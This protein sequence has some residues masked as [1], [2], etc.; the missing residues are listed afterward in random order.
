MVYDLF[1][2]RLSANPIQ[3][4]T[5]H[6]GLTA[7]ILLLVSLTCTPLS[8]WLGLRQMNRLRRP[9]GL[10][11]FFYAAFHLLLFVWADYRFAFDLIWL[12]IGS[13]PYI[14]AG[15]AAFFLLLALAVTSYNFWKKWLGK[16]WK[17]LHRLVYA[18]AILAAL[19]YAW[20][21]KMDL[22]RLTGEVIGPLIAILALAILLLARLPFLRKLFNPRSR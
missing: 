9:I 6:T 3:D 22:F 4:L 8:S 17:R 5:R 7:L 20:V 1:A 18:A 14:Y 16:N 15:A 13:K 2:S 12:D 19:H 11:A 10:L 21:K